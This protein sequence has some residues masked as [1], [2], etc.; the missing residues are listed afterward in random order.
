M[1]T[2]TLSPGV[3]T[4]LLINCFPFVETIG[5]ETSFDLSLELAAAASIFRPIFEFAMASSNDGGG[6]K[7]TTSPTLGG[8]IDLVTRT[9]FAQ[10]KSIA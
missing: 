8:K 4:T 3:A 7:K 2:P 10:K 9:T 1:Y 5:G 6:S